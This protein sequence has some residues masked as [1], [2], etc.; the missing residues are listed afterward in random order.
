M[1]VSVVMPNHNRADALPMTL[2]ALSR[3]TFPASEFEVIV[4]D[5]ASTDGSRELVE[6]F[7]SPYRLRLLKQAGKFGISVARNGGVE[8][9]DSNLIILLDADIIPD[10]GLVSALRTP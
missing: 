3:Q 10:P 7:S 4:V 9:A 2:E 8:A 1:K 5:Q 6:S